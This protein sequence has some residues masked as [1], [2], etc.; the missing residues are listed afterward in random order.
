[1][2]ASQTQHIARALGRGPDPDPDTADRHD[3]PVLP[4]Y[5]VCG[6]ETRCTR[7]TAA[8]SSV[9]EPYAA[10][11]PEPPTSNPTA[12][13]ST[14]TK[15]L[16]RGRGWCAV[17]DA[18]LAFDPLSSQGIITSLNS[19]LFLGAMLARHLCPTDDAETASE[20]GDAL[21]S[22]IK[23]AYEKVRGKYEEGRAHY[24]GI[25]RRFDGDSESAEGADTDASSF[26]RAQRGK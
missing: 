4:V 5:E 26:W 3:V 11:E 23:A 25:V 6:A 15:G 7:C 20:P 21:V 16:A 19:G 2:L 18:A 10:W 14:G 17:G 9:L 24:Y 12:T 1:M 13:S 8:G 22:D